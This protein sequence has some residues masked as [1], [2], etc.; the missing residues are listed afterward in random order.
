V[1]AKTEPS[2][3][4][5]RPVPRTR[6]ARQA[7]GDQRADHPHGRTSSWPVPTWIRWTRRLLSRRPEPTRHH[8]ARPAV[9][10]QCP[11]RH[12]GP[13]EP[14]RAEPDLL[15]AI[16]RLAIG[17]SCGPSE[18]QQGPR[19]MRT[20]SGLVP[21]AADAPT[22]QRRAR[23]A[24]ARS[25]CRS[26]GSSASRMCAVPAR[27]PTPEPLRTLTRSCRCWWSPPDD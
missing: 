24:W 1:P 4:L 25:R 15:A 2:A 22:Y 26:R 11:Y 14:P 7:S 10:P 27:Q 20:V 8:V 17:G 13:A 16:S 5:R 18:D 21:I 3:P 19:S 9:G 6:P 23:L 12:P